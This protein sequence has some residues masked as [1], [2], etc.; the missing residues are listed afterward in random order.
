MRAFYYI[1]TALCG[2]ALGVLLMW[3]LS[4]NTPPA[5]PIVL[6]DTISVTDTIRIAGKTRTIEVARY[7]TIKT[8]DTLTQYAVVPIE[9]KEYRDTFA[10]DTSSIEL[11][12]AFSGYNAR[13]DSVGINYHF[14]VQPRVERQKRG[15]GWC[16][17]PSVQV[18]YGV[19]F[20][21]SV[22][23]AP[24]IGVGVAVGWGYHF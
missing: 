8:F 1:L 22:I 17:M 6:H 24:Y 21:N 9:A 18:G 4:R 16:V 14:E 5:E 19:A 7:D 3:L 15:F 20:G 23:A 2:L 10:T 12:V 13:I 11:A